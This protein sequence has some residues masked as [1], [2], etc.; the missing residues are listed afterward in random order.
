MRVPAAVT[1][2]AIL[3]LLVRCSSSI[4]HTLYLYCHRTCEFNCNFVLIQVQAED[5]RNLKPRNIERPV[6]PRHTAQEW[7]DILA[8]Q[9]ETVVFVKGA[10]PQPGKT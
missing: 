1:S 4:Y 7:R 2:L 10:K 5:V 8:A 6:Y 9:E 3:T